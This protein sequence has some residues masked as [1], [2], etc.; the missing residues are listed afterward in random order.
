MLKAYCYNATASSGL[1]Y[2][3]RLLATEQELRGWQMAGLVPPD[4]LELVGMQEAANTLVAQFEVQAFV[5]AGG[6]LQ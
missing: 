5:Q 3:V 6:A 4:C 1:I 2:S